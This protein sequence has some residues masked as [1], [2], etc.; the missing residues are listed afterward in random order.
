MTGPV[1]VTTFMDEYVPYNDLIP[2]NDY[3]AGLFDGVPTDDIE[4]VMYHPIVSP[5]RI[6]ACSIKLV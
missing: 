1:L 6:L 3:F 2:D 4:D 5:R